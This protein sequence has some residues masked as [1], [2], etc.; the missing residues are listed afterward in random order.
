[1]MVRTTG[2]LSC[3]A[4]M[5]SN[6]V[7]RKDLVKAV[8]SSH[9]LVKTLISHLSPAGKLPAIY[10]LREVARALRLPGA[11]GRKT[12]S[13]YVAQ[14]WIRWVGDKLSALLVLLCKSRRMRRSSFN[15]ALLYPSVCSTS[16]SH[17]PLSIVRSSRQTSS[18]STTHLAHSVPWARS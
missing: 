9:R 6:P 2:L 8:S 5:D 7:L 1:M 11:N 15:P 14:T 12:P 16:P 10:T 18:I 13:I 3:Y 4:M 17:L